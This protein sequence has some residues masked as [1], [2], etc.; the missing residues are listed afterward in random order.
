MNVAVKP[1]IILTAHYETEKL[2]AEVQSVLPTIE[3][4]EE[5]MK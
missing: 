5:K 1:S 3:E 2:L 4:I